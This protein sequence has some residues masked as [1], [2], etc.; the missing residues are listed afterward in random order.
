M[1]DEIEQDDSALGTTKS[2]NERLLGLLLPRARNATESEK[3]LELVIEKTA[4]SKRQGLFLALVA[5]REPAREGEGG[6]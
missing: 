3:I 5:A 4:L 2:T 6:Y 1:K